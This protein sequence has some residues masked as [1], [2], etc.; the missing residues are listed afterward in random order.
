MVMT[1]WGLPLEMNLTKWLSK[2]EDFVQRVKKERKICKRK[3][4]TQNKVELEKKERHGIREG[5]MKT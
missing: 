4:R 2:C 1:Q 5:E 3:L